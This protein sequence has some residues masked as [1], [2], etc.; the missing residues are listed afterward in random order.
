MRV[1]GECTASITP[2]LSSCGPEGPCVLR[3]S[4]KKDDGTLKLPLGCFKLR[5]TKNEGLGGSF[6]LTQ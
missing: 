5:E 3:W 6:F 4:H 2:A 1:F